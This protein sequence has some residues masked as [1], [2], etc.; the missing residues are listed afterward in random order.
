M[1]SWA[2]LLAQTLV[3]GLLVGLMLPVG[4]PSLV[5]NGLWGTVRQMLSSTGVVGGY[6]NDGSAGM[7]RVTMREEGDRIVHGAGTQASNR[8][9]FRLGSETELQLQRSWEQMSDSVR[10]QRY[11]KEPSLPFPQDGS[12]QPQL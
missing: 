6:P 2:G 10:E 12:S 9:T 1:T 5:G 11:K 4:S 7:Q 8:K 3:G